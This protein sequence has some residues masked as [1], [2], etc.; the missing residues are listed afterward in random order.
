MPRSPV[1]FQT[2]SL[3]IFLTAV[4]AY[5][6][7]AEIVVDTV[8][9]LV[10]AVN[11]TQNGGDRT[12]LIVDGNY[13]LNG[14]YLRIAVSG[15]TVRSQSGNREN[16]VLDGNYQS[17]EI[18]Q[19]IASNAT[20]ADLTLKRAFDHPIHVIAT[21]NN[22][23]DNTLIRNVHIID[24]GQQAIKINPDSER[25]HF[26]NNGRIRGSL[27]ELTDSGRTKVWD[28]NGSCYTGGVDAHQADSW[29]IEDNEIRGFWCADGLSEHG[30]HFWSDSSNT[31]VQRNRIVDCDRGIG[32]G[33]G[34]SGHSGGVIRNNMIYHGSDHGVSD[35]GISL[36]SATGAQVYNNTIFH[37]HSYPNGIEYRFAESNDLTIINNLTNRA[38]ASRQEGSATLLSNNVDDA[39]SDWFVD[40]AGGDLHLIAERSGVTGAAIAISGLDDDYDKQGRPLD[41]GLDIGA[42]EYSDTGSGDRVTMSWLFLLM[43]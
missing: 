25:T 19:I 37:E 30:I 29:I 16:V 4:T 43:N 15:V 28:R 24:P 38:I 27:I 22:D 1:F 26:V 40:T 12:I 35:V 39:E 34:S 6:A 20:V 5:S 3:L 13:L 8:S 11:N 36:E 17:T 10:D 21:S 2:V 23:V 33:L 42:D 9:Q 18:F 14:S 31:L 32:F 7:C 41:S